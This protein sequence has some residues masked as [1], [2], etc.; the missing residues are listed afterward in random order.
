[1]TAVFS[2]AVDK[3]TNIYDLREHT[4]PNRAFELSQGG[5]ATSAVILANFFRSIPKGRS[6]LLPLSSAV[7]SRS[8]RLN[9]EKRRSA[10]TAS[11]RRGK[12][13]GKKKRETTR[14]MPKRNVRRYSN[15]TFQYPPNRI[16]HQSSQLPISC[17]KEH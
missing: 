5:C 2:T 9:L 14:A 6:L 1:M 15:S 3:H 8:R 10:L 4:V 11:F 12:K 17:L 7:T 16:S 13:N